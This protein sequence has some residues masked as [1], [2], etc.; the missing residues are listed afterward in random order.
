MS[1]NL[2]FGTSSFVFEVQ[3]FL[4]WFQFIG[5]IPEEY[6]GLYLRVEVFMTLEK[7]EK[8]I[9]KPFPS[10]PQSPFQSESKCG[11]ST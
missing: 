1:R 8:Y 5:T 6:L 2:P 9:N 10:S 3:L 4:S 11:I 7:K